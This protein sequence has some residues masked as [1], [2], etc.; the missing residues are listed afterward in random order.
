MK[1]PIQEL[2]SQIREALAALKA[3]NLTAR[4]VDTEQIGNLLASAM[5]SASM[6]EPW[7]RIQDDFR[8]LSRIDVSGLAIAGEAIR[9][10]G[11]GNLSPNLSLIQRAAFPAIANTQQALSAFAPNAQMIARFQSDFDRIAKQID[12]LQKWAFEPLRELA[13]RAGRTQAVR[14]AFLAYGLWLAPSMPEELVQKIVELHRRGVG[15]GTVHSMVSSWYARGDCELLEEVLEACN[16]NPG[17][18]K[19]VK[20]IHQ[21]LQGHR[22]GLYALSVPA[23][24]LQ[25]EGI[26][27]D[28]VR[29]N[30]LM[31]K[32]GH[33]TKK[34][35]MTA[36][37]DTPCSPLDVTTYAGVTV[38]LDYIE[39]DMYMFVDFDKDYQ[40]IIRDKRL[41]A[42][43]IRHG[44][45]L[46]Y[47]SRM[48][49]L[50]LFLMIDVLALLE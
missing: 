32:I 1:Y 5:R 6:A 49:S 8:L 36:L 11:I 9:R 3:L 22:Q 45:Q 48:N 44:R 39:N 14:D 15:A 37:K 43:P 13:R 21:S 33:K 38:L 46:S 18:A 10:L 2:N 4:L 29:A 35:I 30:K 26:A 27:A 31:P 20:T 40:R 34:I 47:D 16:N 23:L 50:R 17:L 28:Y 12:Q 42:H 25:V 19:R 41:L 24:L 7:L